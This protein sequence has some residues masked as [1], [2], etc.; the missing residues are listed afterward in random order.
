MSHECCPD[1][2]YILDAKSS[3]GC[4]RRYRM[5]VCLKPPKVFYRQFLQTPP[6]PTL[7]RFLYA[8][9]RW[10]E[11]PYERFYSLMDGEDTT[12]QTMQVHVAHLRRWLEARGI[13]I[14]IQAIR[15]FGYRL[16][17]AA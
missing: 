5:V 14:E 10:G 7:I 13:P 9:L 17:E 15:D 1:C 11:A 12:V 16:K 8:L 4:V 6:T 3:D 2:G